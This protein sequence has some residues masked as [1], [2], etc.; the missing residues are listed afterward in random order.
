MSRE[1]R[2]RRKGPK[3]QPGLS[4]SNAIWVLDREADEWFLVTAWGIGGYILSQFAARVYDGKIV[5]SWK[6]SFDFAFYCSAGLLIL[7]AISVFLLKAPHH[8][9]EV[10]Q[11]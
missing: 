5:A 1:K 3:P 10:E 11:S 9:V 7:A 4:V 8:T 6:G 2:R